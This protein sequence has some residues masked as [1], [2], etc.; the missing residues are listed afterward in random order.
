[1]RVPGYVPVSKAA[2]TLCVCEETIRNWAEKS[3][4]SQDSK[5]KDV[6]KNRLTGRILISLADVNRLKRVM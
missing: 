2:R 1:M 4:C 5:L 6:K 3:L